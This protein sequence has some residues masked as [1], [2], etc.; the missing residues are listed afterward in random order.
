MTLAIEAPGRGRSASI[1]PFAAMLGL[2]AVVGARWWATVSGTANGLAIGSAFGLGLLAIALGLGRNP[3]GRPGLDDDGLPSPSA[4]ARIH[5]GSRRL[6]DVMRAGAVGSLG[7]AV[8]IAVAITTRRSGLPPLAQATAFGPWVAVTIL[9][10]AAEELLLRG[11]LFDAIARV[12]GPTAAI[13]ITTVLFALMHVPLYGWH[14]VPLDLG[15]G[16]WLAGL[17]LATGGVVAPG[18]AHALADLATWWL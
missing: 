13:A 18:I 16:L 17:R 10:A 15:V 4:V 8:L 12:G 11:R 6:T 9:V 3:R 1:A 2:G 5:S 14:V 7:A